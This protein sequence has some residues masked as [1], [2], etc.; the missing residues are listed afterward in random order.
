MGIANW[1]HR[2]PVQK[3]QD[4]VEGPQWALHRRFC[5]PSTAVLHWVTFLYLS[6]L[7]GGLNRSLKLPPRFLLSVKGS[8]TS[9]DHLQKG[10]SWQA[11]P[12]SWEK[13]LWGWGEGA[14]EGIILILSFHELPLGSEASHLCKGGR[15]AGLCPSAAGPAMRLKEL[16]GRAGGCSCSVS[17]DH[18]S[19]FQYRNLT[20]W[21]GQTGRVSWYF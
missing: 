13:G 17:R 16:G 20:W 18:G 21:S 7:E 6:K 3:S 4:T 9:R 8:G 2:A 14:W 1:V 15:K 11:R 10:D 12:G 19:H 5:T